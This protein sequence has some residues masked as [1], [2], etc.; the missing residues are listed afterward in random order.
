MPPDLN[1]FSLQPAVQ[2]RGL[3]L[4]L[5][6]TALQEAR[7][8]ALWAIWHFLA[9]RSHLFFLSW[10]PASLDSWDGVRWKVPS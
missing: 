5:L 2:L 1:R 4:R 7:S 3:S 6:L 8:G 9:A 10:H